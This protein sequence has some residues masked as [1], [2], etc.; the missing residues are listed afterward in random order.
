MS[1]SRLRNTYGNITENYCYSC[2][3]SPYHDTLSRA[4]NDLRM[5]GNPLYGPGYHGPS[6]V[7]GYC[8]NC[9]FSPYR[10]V[11]SRA[12]QDLRMK[13]NPLY[14][15]GYHGPSTVEGYCPTCPKKNYGGKCDGV[16]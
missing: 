14:G 6:T 10:D 11:L 15:P 5:K 8:Y 7:E 16:T 13:G 3:F 4:Y 12:Y 9:G 2:G 1:Y